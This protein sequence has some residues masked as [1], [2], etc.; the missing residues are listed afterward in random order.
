MTTHL[1]AVLLALALWAVASAQ[2]L[3][4]PVTRTVDHVD[5]YHGTQG[6]GPVSLAR[7]RHVGGDGGV[8][9]GAEQGDVRVSREDPVSRAAD[10]SG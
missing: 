7:G 5:T 1:R 3:H 9:R 8:G 2:G 10:R 4:Y 6:A